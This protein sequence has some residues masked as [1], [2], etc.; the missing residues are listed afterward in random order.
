MWKQR[1]QIMRNSFPLFI[2]LRKHTLRTLSDSENRHNCAVPGV[3]VVDISLAE[4]AY[5]VVKS[6]V[7]PAV[8]DPLQE[9]EAEENG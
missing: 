7:D 4:N 1:P 3:E 8:L 6:L 9:E 5:T 2:S